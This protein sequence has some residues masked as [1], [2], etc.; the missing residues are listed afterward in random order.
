LRSLAILFAIYLTLALL[1]WPK[2]AA[3]LESRKARKRREER[4]ESNASSVDGDYA[5]VDSDDDEGANSSM[6]TSDFTASMTTQSR[7]AATGSS[8]RASQ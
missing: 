5:L 3:I 2:I 6:A 8:A 4:R 1:S 7:P